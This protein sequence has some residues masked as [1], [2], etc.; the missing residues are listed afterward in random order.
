MTMTDGQNTTPVTDDTTATPVHEPVKT[1][2]QIAEEKKAAEAE[3][4][5]E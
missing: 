5:A 2:E 4:A 3:K 1:P